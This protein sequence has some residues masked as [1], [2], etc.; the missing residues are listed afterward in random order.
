MA[1]S[2]SLGAGLKVLFD[3]ASDACKS[4]K[5]DLAFAMKGISTL[6]AVI[7]CAERI[8]SWSDDDDKNNSND[9]AQQQKKDSE[10]I[11]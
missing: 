4:E 8:Y 1:L 3:L 5:E 2:T 7:G 9:N 11:R 6:E 10:S